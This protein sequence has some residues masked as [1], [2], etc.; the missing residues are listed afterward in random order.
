MKQNILI[1]FV[2]RIRLGVAVSKYG[3]VSFR[4]DKDDGISD[5]DFIEYFLNDLT[6][7]ITA[8][9]LIKRRRIS[10]EF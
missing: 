2:Y 3:G 5:N 8:G 6:K 1:E 10:S 9:K 7:Y 4:T